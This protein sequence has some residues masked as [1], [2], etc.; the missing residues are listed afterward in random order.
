MPRVLPVTEMQA[1]RSRPGNVRS[2][3]CSLSCSR[4]LYPAAVA[5]SP[6]TGRPLSFLQVFYDP[7]PARGPS[8]AQ[9]FPFPG[10]TAA[11]RT[12]A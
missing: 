6:R 1:P 5:G 4:G 2:E 11:A 9:A 3:E 12:R 7:R 10:A 8:T